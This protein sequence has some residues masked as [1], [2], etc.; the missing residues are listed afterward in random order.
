MN[1]KTS[2]QLIRF[3]GAGVLSLSVILGTTSGGVRLGF[4]PHM[5]YG[6]GL[7]LAILLNF[8]ICRYLIFQTREHDILSEFIK[9]VVSIGIWRVFEFMG[10]VLLFDVLK[11]QYQ[12]AAITIAVLMFG[13]K[14]VWCRLVVFKKDD[15]PNTT[16]GAI[17]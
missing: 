1:K 16:E 12:V 6:I 8:A 13:F 7:A 9:F 3:G 4:D 15:N 10:F 5:A 2:W 11:F 17:G 14:F